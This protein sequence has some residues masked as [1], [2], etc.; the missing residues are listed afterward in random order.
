LRVAR[1]RPTIRAVPGHIWTD[2]IHQQA[3]PCQRLVAESRAHL[4]AQLDALLLDRRRTGKPAPRLKVESS[5]HSTSDVGRPSD[6]LVT[7]DRE[8]WQDDPQHA[9]WLPKALPGGQT[10]VWLPANASVKRANALLSARKLCF[11]NLGSYDKQSVFGAITTG[12]HGTGK[13]L[14]PLAD[15]VLALDIVVVRPDAGGTLRCESLRLERA[16]APISTARYDADAKKDPTMARRVLD[17]ALFDAAVVSMGCFGIVT[18]VVVRARAEFWLAEDRTATWWQDAKQ[19]IDP[20]SPS[21]EPWL[22]LNITARKLPSTGDH[23]VLVTRRSECKKGPI[24][25]RND[26][27]TQVARGQYDQHGPDRNDVATFLARIGCLAP[28]IAN[29]IA[30]NSFQS[31]VAEKPFKSRSDRVLFTSIGDYVAVSSCEVSVPSADWKAAVTTTLATLAALTADGY[32]SLTPVGVR[33]ST[34]SRHPMAPQFGRPTC[35]I[36]VGCLVG[37]FSTVHSGDG[38][39]DVIDHILSTVESALMTQ[40]Q[41][42]PHW[43]QRFFSSKATIEKAYPAGTWAAWKTERAKVDPSGVFDNAFSRR[44]GL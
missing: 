28:E 15:L 6:V 2:W 12:T 26:R 42:R 38:T 17:T 19:L 30:W 24:F 10:P 36:E 7:L 8:R 16:D 35:T 21:E 44:L 33:F 25:A 31:E 18:G 5:G 41:G 27:R 11:P 9:L 23:G 22:D 43:G 14:P 32:H 29:G 13:D 39:W 3:T 37:I 20:L 4:V 40:H 1:E 34:A